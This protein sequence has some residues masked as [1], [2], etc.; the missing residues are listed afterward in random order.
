LTLPFPDATLRRAV[1]LLYYAV[2][3][4]RDATQPPAARLSGGKR[5]GGEGRMT[6]HA[7]L[8]SRLS[9]GENLQRA[10]RRWRKLMIRGLKR[11]GYGDIRP[12]F[13]PVLLPLSREDGLPI[14]E[15]GRRSGLS[16]Q[17]M[18][19]IVRLMEKRGLVRTCRD[20]Q[21]SRVIRVHLAP[22]GR[23]FPLVAQEVLAEIEGLLRTHLDEA[24]L[25]AMERAL[26]TLSRL[27]ER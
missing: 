10:S 1:R 16:K 19:E 26:Q 27:G 9:L 25:T 3:N 17:A 18:T 23:A 24:D 5:P 13:A 2:Q 8:E 14:G 20:E 7:A 4:V 15:L 21:D 11:Y 12:S 6:D 22:R